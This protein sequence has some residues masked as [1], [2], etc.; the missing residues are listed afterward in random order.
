MNYRIIYSDELYH[1][2]VKGMKWGVRKDP[3]VANYLNARS[4]YKKAYKSYSKAF[5][6]SYNFSGR[7]PVTQYIKK[8][9]N[10]AKSNALWDDT[11]SKADSARAA[12]SELRSARK[13]VAKKAAN[14][15]K[16]ALQKKLAA[17]TY[18]EKSGAG[19]AAERAR[20][21]QSTKIKKSDYIKQYKAD[22]K[23]AKLERKE[24]NKAAQDYKRYS[25]KPYKDIAKAY[26]SQADVYVQTYKAAKNATG[27]RNKAKAAVK[28]Y[29]ETPYRVI[30][31]TGTYNTTYKRTQTGRW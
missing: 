27:L 2:G 20:K 28:A 12:R 31:L 26:M 29:S 9:K 5:D 4:N 25:N 23:A 8:S 18:A 17:P 1:H 30:G 11:L 13:V 24:P 7:H 21:A 19:K 10:Y 3:D 16:E 15:G 14:A 6:K 22:K